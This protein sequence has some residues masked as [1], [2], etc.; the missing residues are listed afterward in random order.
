MWRRYRDTDQINIHFNGYTG[1]C[2][3]YNKL[4][5]VIIM[6]AVAPSYLI[7]LVGCEVTIGHFGVLGERQRTHVNCLGL[8]ST[9][10]F[11][12]SRVSPSIGIPGP[13]LWMQCLCSCIVLSGDRSSSQQSHSFISVGIDGGILERVIFPLPFSFFTTSY[14]FS[15]KPG[16][17]NGEH[18]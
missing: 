5:G 12:S 2:V 3:R 11:F 9:H 4:K 14:H 7:Q 15:R 16:R 1:Y 17:K 6:L 8:W 10:F 13:K 18:R